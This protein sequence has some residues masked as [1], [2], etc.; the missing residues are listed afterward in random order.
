MK[1][2]TSKLGRVVPDL[3]G[4]LGTGSISYTRHFCLC[5]VLCSHLWLGVPRQTNKKEDCKLDRRKWR[6]CDADSRTRDAQF[7]IE[8]SLR[9]H[10]VDWTERLLE[11]YFLFEFLSDVY[12]FI[13]GSILENFSQLSEVSE[14]AEEEEQEDD[15]IVEVGHQ[16]CLGA[17]MLR[18]NS[19]PGF[20]QLQEFQA[21]SRASR[22]ER[23]DPGSVGGKNKC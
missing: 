19:A 13:V 15:E 6:T 10:P 3:Q 14:E 23:R 12:C 4:A 11:L 8:C 20:L 7:C 17:S 9:S 18:Q 2:S 16:K 21:Q 5:G 1:G 22:W